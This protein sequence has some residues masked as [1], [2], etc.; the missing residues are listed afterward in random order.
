VPEQYS[1]TSTPSIGLTA[2]TDPHCLYST[3]IPL[4]P[5]WAVQA[6]QNLNACTVQ[7]YLYFPYWPYSLYRA[8]E[9]VQYSYTSTPHMGRTA[10]TEPQYQYSTAVPLLPLL[11][12]QPI[13]SL[14]A[15]IV[16]L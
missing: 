6:V 4:L 13:K 12:V 16:Q 7:L 9:P 5:I 3:A 1:Y 8:A 2:C 11:T 10:C 14:S 15:C